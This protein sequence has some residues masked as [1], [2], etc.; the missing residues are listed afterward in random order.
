MYHN[1]PI[2]GS[3]VHELSSVNLFCSFYDS[4]PLSNTVLLCLLTA[5]YKQK[6]MLLTVFTK[7]PSN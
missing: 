1:Q 6:H 4:H 3:M 2:M 5:D 7:L